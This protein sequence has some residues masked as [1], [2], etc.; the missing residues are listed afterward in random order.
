MDEIREINL[1]K[2]GEQKYAQPEIQS[3]LDAIRQDDEHD[4]WVEMTHSFFNE[5]GIEEAITD[6][7]TSESFRSLSEAERQEVERLGL[8]SLNP[9]NDL[10]WKIVKP[11]EALAEPSELEVLRLIPAIG[12]DALLF[13]GVTLDDIDRVSPM[14]AEAYARLGFKRKLDFANFVGASILAKRRSYRDTFIDFDLSEVDGIK[15]TVGVGGDGNGDFRIRQSEFY[16]EG[17]IDPAG[18]NVMYAPKG[19]EKYFG[20][21]HS[22]EPLILVALLKHIDR[23]GWSEDTQRQFIKSHLSLFEQKDDGR[24]G[25]GLY[26][27]YGESDGHY[28]INDVDMYY[29]AGLAQ[30]AKE[31]GDFVWTELS[32]LYDRVNNL[33]F[34]TEGEDLVVQYGTRDKE[35]KWAPINDHCIKIPPELL[36][37]FLLALLN[38]TKNGYGR[39]SD[40][41]LINILNARLETY[42][43][44]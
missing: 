19:P 3:I 39:T 35:F 37:D 34:R 41:C 23:L 1:S 25:G 38:Q 43:H 31:K 11:N 32:N 26:A 44:Q 5:E 7:K 36:G 4:P 10:S 20:A 15:Q 27:D 14:Y 8:L 29:S 24:R 13:S 9:Y 42:W 33:A 12:A 16:L 21:Y 22:V 2:T 30:L 28:Q 18:T 6:F 17:S 40:F